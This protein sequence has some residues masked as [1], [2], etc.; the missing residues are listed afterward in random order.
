VFSIRPLA[1]SPIVSRLATDGRLLREA[2]ESGRAATHAAFASLIP[3]A[4]SAARSDGLG[5]TL[6]TVLRT[7]CA[8][9]SLR[10]AYQGRA[11]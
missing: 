11:P 7:L 6:G 4:P 5:G 1:G 9:D 10:D 3:C 8:P 2:F